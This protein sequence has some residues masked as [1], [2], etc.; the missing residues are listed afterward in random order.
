[1]LAES[2]FLKRPGSELRLYLFVASEAQRKST[3]ALEL[4]NQQ[5]REITG[6]SPASQRRARTKLWEH[7]FIVPIQ[8]QGE[9]W[10]YIVWDPVKDEPA[11]AVPEKFRE[12][13]ES[14]KRASRKPL[15]SPSWDQL[16]HQ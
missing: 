11:K 3:A 9:C 14:W 2:D 8:R 15:H 4:S 12:T 16:G 6:L 10:L 1:M 13:Y 7:R 5:I